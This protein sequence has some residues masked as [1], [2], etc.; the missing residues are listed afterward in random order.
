MELYRLVPTSH[1]GFGAAGGVVR[2]SA[3][4]PAWRPWLSSGWAS[5]AAISLENMGQ[6]NG[7]LN[8]SFRKKEASYI[9]LRE[10]SL[11]RLLV[12]PMFSNEFAASDAQPDGPSK[13]SS[14]GLGGARLGP[15]LRMPWAWLGNEWGPGLTLGL[16][17][18]LAWP[19][20]V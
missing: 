10:L 7:L 8:G 5:D 17:L 9:L 14:P 20:A 15:S 13:G 16:G 6:T 4:P 11:S 12:C 3:H 19:L 2:L 1:P 18:G